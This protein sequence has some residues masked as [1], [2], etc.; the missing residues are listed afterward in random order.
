M[1]SPT[2]WASEVFQ[3]APCVT[4]IGKIVPPAPP[5]W[6][7]SSTNEIGMPATA[8]AVGATTGQE[9]EGR[10]TKSLTQARLVEESELHLPQVGDPAVGVVHRAAERL[11]AVLGLQAIV[12]AGGRPDGR[13]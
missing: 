13:A 11:G 8:R 3:L 6:D 1:A 4:P 5:A 9:S 12:G 2:A 7:V 10:P